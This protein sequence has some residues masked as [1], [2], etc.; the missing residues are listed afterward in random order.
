LFLFVFFESNYISPVDI[1]IGKKAKPNRYDKNKEASRLYHQ[2]V[3]F[4]LLEYNLSYLFFLFVIHYSSKSV[5]H[6]ILNHIYY[7]SFTVKIKIILSVDH[8]GSQLFLRVEGDRIWRK[9]INF[10]RKCSHTTFWQSLNR[11]Y[12]NYGLSA[13]F[14]CQKV[15]LFDVLPEKAAKS[16]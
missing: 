6:H 16:A 9:F 8:H 13:R 1:K 3:L 12:Q 2:S 11:K 14:C 5:L 10:A 7:S 4:C 15:F